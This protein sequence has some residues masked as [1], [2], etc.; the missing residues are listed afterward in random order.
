MQLIYS[1]PT[2][3]LHGYFFLDLNDDNCINL[4]ISWNLLNSIIV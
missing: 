4:I 1:S 2:D 3:D